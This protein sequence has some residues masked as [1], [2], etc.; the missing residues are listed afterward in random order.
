MSNFTHS[1]CESCYAALERGRV[2]SRV[3]S[4]LDEPRVKERCCHCGTLHVSGIYY[5]AD[6]AKMKC[7]GAHD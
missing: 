2:P 1:L 6:P 7:Q 4:D 3:N 5:R